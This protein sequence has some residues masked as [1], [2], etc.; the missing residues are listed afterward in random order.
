MRVDKKR[1]DALWEKIERLYDEIK[2]LDPDGKIEPKISLR[3]KK[4]TCIL[5]ADRTKGD[6]K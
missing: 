3:K 5:R 6:V 1:I 4:E 2:M